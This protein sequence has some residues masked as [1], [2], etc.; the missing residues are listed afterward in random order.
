MRCGEV[1]KTEKWVDSIQ[2]SEE[3]AL[4]IRPLSKYKEPVQGWEAC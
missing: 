1:Q 4:F 3:Y 2:A